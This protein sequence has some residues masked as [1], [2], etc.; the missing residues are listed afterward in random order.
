MDTYSHFTKEV[1]KEAIDLFNKIL[2][3]GRFIF[4]R[5]SITIVIKRVGDLKPK[6]YSLFQQKNKARKKS[7]KVKKT[8]RI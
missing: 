5:S 3:F 4:S 8:A 7:T 2:K 1:K 6:L